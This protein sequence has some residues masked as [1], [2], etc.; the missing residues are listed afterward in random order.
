RAA[1]GATGSP[2]G[3]ASRGWHRALHRAEPDA[4]LH[5]F[6]DLD[7]RQLLDGDQ[8]LAALFVGEDQQSVAIEGGGH[9]PLDVVRRLR[10]FEDDLARRVL[11]TDLDLHRPT[12][13]VAANVAANRSL[14]CRG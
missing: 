9:E 7:V 6:A 4:A 13:V 11:H 14:C 3:R 5:S 8:H 2:A 12:S 1:G 10:T